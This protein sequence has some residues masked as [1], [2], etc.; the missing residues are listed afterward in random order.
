MAEVAAG[1][2]HTCTLLYSGAVV[3]WGFNGDGELGIGDTTDRYTPTA[4]SGLASGR[5]RPGCFCAIFS[6]CLLLSFV[7]LK[8]RTGLWLVISST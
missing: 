3:C 1:G 6:W 2:H 8:F 5:C 4:V 7:I